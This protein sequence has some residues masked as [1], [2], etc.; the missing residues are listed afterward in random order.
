MATSIRT[1]E[2]K[3]IHQISSCVLRKW[4]AAWSLK[5]LLTVNSKKGE[6]LPSYIRLNIFKDRHDT[7]L[8]NP[9]CK[10]K[11]SWEEINCQPFHN[12]ITVLVI[13]RAKMFQ[14]WNSGN[15]WWAC[16][17][18]F[19]SFIDLWC[20][21]AVLLSFSVSDHNKNFNMVKEVLSRFTDVLH[22]AYLFLYLRAWDFQ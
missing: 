10:N 6:L 2:K 11:L 4:A 1:T 18:M 22:I 14:L 13:F 17:T 19:W 16:P 3:L 12:W 8:H 5:S 15:L 9:I 7:F 20:L 21:I